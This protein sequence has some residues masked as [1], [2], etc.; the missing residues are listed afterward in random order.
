ME[1]LH[2]RY[3]ESSDFL[4][5]N[6]LKNAIRYE[7][8]LIGDKN[9]GYDLV[10]DKWA[11]ENEDFF[12]KNGIELDRGESRICIYCDSA[13][14]IIKLNI[15][16]ATNPYFASKTSNYCL[17]FCRKEAEIY[18]KA[19][20]LGL[21][22]FFCGIEFFQ[23]ISDIDFYLQPKIKISESKI[24]E[25]FQKLSES[26]N[27]DE[28]DFDEFDRLR[29]VFGDDPEVETL[30]DFLCSEW[31]KDMVCSD[32]HSGNIGFDSVGRPVLFDYAGFI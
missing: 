20:S 28:L 15:N 27:L 22:R 29:A 9:Y 16:R 19:R 31:D 32:L 12:Q 25:K 7:P 21:E 14:D 3:K 24:S 10:F 5:E 8:F 2:F 6:G 4:L 18:A 1:Y 11:E 23:K 17:D 13:P 26:E 30:C